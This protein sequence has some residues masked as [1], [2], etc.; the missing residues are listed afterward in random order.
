MRNRIVLSVLLPLIFLLSI[1]IN[2][3]E[4]IVLSQYIHNQYAINPAFGGSR[5]AFTFF[6]AYKMQWSGVEQAPSKQLLTLH[7]PLKNDHMALGLKVSNSTFSVINYT[8]VMA[9]Y[10]YR[11]NVGASSYLALGLEGGVALNA[12]NWSQVESIDLDDPLFAE[13]T[14][15]TSPSAGAGLAYYGNKFYISLSAPSL[16]YYNQDV[17]AKGEFAPDKINYLFSGGY[18]FKPLD[19]FAF[20]PSGLVIF[21]PS[22]DL[23]WDAGLTTIYNDIVWGTVAYRSL[24]Q[25]VVGLA[26]QPIPTLR[27]GYSYDYGIGDLATFGGGSHEISIQYDFGY[28]IKSSN[29]KFF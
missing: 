12:S 28:K 1:S 13:N 5:N 3:Q 2:A 23:I 27:I 19:L 4:N 15:S 16:F 10:T 29:P 14:A 7:S 24:G 8:N 21:N 6:G 17:E 25:V 9:S 20:Q 26:I 18:I 22:E 11:V